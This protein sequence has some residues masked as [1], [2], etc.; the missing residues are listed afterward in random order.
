MAPRASRASMAACRDD[1]GGGRAPCACRGEFVR[2]LGLQVCM[3]VGACRWACDG[4]TTSI[5]DHEDG[6][7]KSMLLLQNHLVMD[8][9]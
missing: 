7:V 8:K 5:M 4:A 9:E 2:L 1:L 6:R 3:Y